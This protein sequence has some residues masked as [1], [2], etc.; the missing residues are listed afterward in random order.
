MKVTAALL[1]PA[2]IR[3]EL[4]IELRRRTKTVIV[5][6]VFG[7]V[8]AVHFEDEVAALLFAR[9]F[10]PFLSTL[11]PVA[12]V[13]TARRDDG[14]PVFWTDDGDRSL[15]P[16]GASSASIAALVDVVA[17]EAVFRRLPEAISFHA[18]AI[19]IDHRAVAIAGATTAGKT[20][21]ALACVRRGLPLYT[22]ERC[23]VMNGSVHPFPRA[24][25]VRPDGAKLLASEHHAGLQALPPL[26]NEGGRECIV[27]TDRF[28]L[29]TPR[30]LTTIFFIAGRDQRVTIE[31]MSR[32]EALVA[33][34]QAL[35][36]PASPLERIERAAKLLQG[37]TTL[38]LTLGSPDETACAILAAVQAREPS[39]S[40][41]K[42]A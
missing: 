42:S 32:S 13:Y 1:Q 37:V 28:E 7:V 22:D 6:D 10:G 23:V 21:T 8:L 27:P 25:S 20:T 31:P 29:A 41:A 26:A 18:A 38:R 15:W 19:Q 17:M 35:F 33:A 30:R 4:L 2:T 24:L 39:V 9:R 36:T 11:T 14:A 5:L 3:D 34:A 40:D 16:L 12:H